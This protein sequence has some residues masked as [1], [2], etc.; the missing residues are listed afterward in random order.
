MFGRGKFHAGVLI[1]P[2]EPFDPADEQL[3][4][5]FRRSIWSVHQ[6]FNFWLV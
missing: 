2:E 3:L 1:F 5:E 6:P 4:I